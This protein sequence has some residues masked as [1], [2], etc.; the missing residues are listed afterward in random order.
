VIRSP[1]KPWPGSL[2]SHQAFLYA[3]DGELVERLEPF[4]RA[5]RAEGEATVAALTRRHQALLREALGADADGVVFL[6]CENVYVR[7]IQTLAAHDKRVRGLLAAGATRVRVTG[8]IPLGTAQAAW[9]DWAIYEAILN[10][11]FAERP[12]SILCVYDARS[13]PDELLEAIWQSHDHV[14]VP[15]RAPASGYEEPEAV[16]SA[17][18]PTP[19]GRRGLPGLRPLP[20]T[21]DPVAFREALAAVLAGAGLPA[22]AAFDML[23]AAHEVFANALQHGGGV[24]ETRAGCV[25]GWFVCEVD[26][27]GPGLDDPLAGWLPPPPESDGQ[28]GLWI[29]RRLVS[30]LELLPHAGGGSTA[31]LWL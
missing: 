28:A 1:G 2:V 29:A 22:T 8:E 6:D 10:R 12:V 17:P 14:G 15:G 16:L 7:P 31:R 18:T 19:L 27:P 5:G 24:T 25:D 20:A 9:K 30:R 23:V 13:L 26:D 11:A 4:L 21:D 3:D